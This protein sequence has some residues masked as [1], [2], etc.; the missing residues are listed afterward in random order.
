MYKREM[1][2]GN[3]GIYTLQDGKSFETAR[4]GLNV[5][6]SNRFPLENRS[7]LHPLGPCP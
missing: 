1:V 6:I 2:G 3:Y 7:R 4:L 5:T